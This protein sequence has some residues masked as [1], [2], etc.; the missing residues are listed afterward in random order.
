MSQCQEVIIGCRDGGLGHSP[1]ALLLQNRKEVPFPTSICT[2]SSYM[3]EFECIEIK[4]EKI[5]EHLCC[6]AVNF[7]RIK[8]SNF[9]QFFG[10]TSV[11]ID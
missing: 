1:M 7:F 8:R 5:S 2:A 3:A 6:D 4:Y 10:Q 9:S 11:A